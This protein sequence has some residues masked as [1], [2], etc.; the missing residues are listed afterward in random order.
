MASGPEPSTAKAHAEKRSWQRRGLTAAGQALL[1]VAAI[2]AVTEWQTRHL[3]A[4]WSP[5]PE[6]VLH[7]LDGEQ[8]SLASERGKTVVLY[9]FAPWCSVCSASSA[10]IAALRRARS[11]SE[12]AVYAVGL[13]WSSRDELTRFAHDHRLGV[14]VLVGDDDVQRRFRIDAFPTIY[15]IDARGRVRDRLVGYTTA[16]GLR[17]RTP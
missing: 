8:V 17:L 3:L 1:V 4:R 14:P 12:V 13:A 11:S 6:L 9:F 5:A 15:V 7:T 2:V 16:L 10:N